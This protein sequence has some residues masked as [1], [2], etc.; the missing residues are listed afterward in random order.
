MSP[1]SRTRDDSHYLAVELAKLGRK[2]WRSNKHHFAAGH[3]ALAV[4]YLSCLGAVRGPSLDLDLPSDVA[5]AADAPHDAG[6][7]A[8]E[9]RAPVKITSARH[10]CGT[11]EAD[12]NYVSFELD[13][14]EVRDEPERRHTVDIYDTSK[15][16]AGETLPQ[17]SCDASLDF[18]V[19]LV[20]TCACDSP[21]AS[22][23]I[24]KHSVE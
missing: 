20:N 18:T 1:K 4:K 24:E 5:T 17:G 9:L 22:L 21:S 6:A 10:L 15:T 19:H 23:E 11:F 2:L 14:P 16:D 12:W 13:A 8:G 3:V 7:S